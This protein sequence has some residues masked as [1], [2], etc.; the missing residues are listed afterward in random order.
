MVA[1]PVFGRQLW[2]S[3]FWEG[4]PS[5]WQGY[6]PAAKTAPSLPPWDSASVPHGMPAV[7][8]LLG[9]KEINDRILKRQ[10]RKSLKTKSN[11]IIK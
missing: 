5:V 10:L 7:Q 9:S 1:L 8:S 4:P 11:I 2:E 3:P 6:R